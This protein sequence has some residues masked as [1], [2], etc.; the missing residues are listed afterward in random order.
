M[1]DFLMHLFDTSDFPARWHCGRWTAGHGWLH[2]LSDLGVWS[3]YFAIPCILVSF[4]LRRR[5]IPFR[6]VFWLFGAFILA[7]GTTHLMEAIIF[8]HPLYR[9]AGVIKLLTAIISWGTVI[10]LV[11]IVPKALAMRSPEELER[12]IKERT[13]ELIA[14]NETLRAEARERQRAEA[15]INR[16]NHELQRRA[17]ELQTILNIVPIGVA[18]AHDPQCLRI[19][20]NPYMSD[21]LNVPAWTNASLTAPQHERP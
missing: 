11:P 20:H 16:L 4:V 15:E 1:F 14:A 6:S 21:L 17:D 7:C 5:D 10:A 8:W 9:L 13:A 2:I 12:E 19:T 3:A 18:I